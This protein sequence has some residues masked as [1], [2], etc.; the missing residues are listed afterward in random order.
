M[1]VYSQICPGVFNVNLWLETMAVSWTSFDMF[2]S[3][4]IANLSISEG[5]YMQETFLKRLIHQLQRLLLLYCNLLKNMPINQD[6]THSPSR[7]LSD[8]GIE[9]RLLRKSNLIFVP[10][11]Q[12]YQ[13]G[14]PFN[15]MT[16]G[17]Y[18]MIVLEVF[19]GA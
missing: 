12:L 6:D 11:N 4:V 15:I 8:K 9:P 10:T 2:I 16:S 5:P 13:I 3:N 14:I 1:R 7:L 18:L 17:M 19:S